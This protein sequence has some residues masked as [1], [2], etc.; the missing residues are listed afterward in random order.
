[1][2]ARL[3]FLFFV[4]LVLGSFVLA[5]SFLL[6]CENHL[7]AQSIPICGREL[8]QEIFILKFLYSAIS[9]FVL[10]VV[11]VIL[12]VMSFSALAVYLAVAVPTQLMCME[13]VYKLA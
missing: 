7:L 1:M 8:N 3:L 11:Q 10:V 5:T 6:D 9:T 2:A 13:M 4:I 12:T